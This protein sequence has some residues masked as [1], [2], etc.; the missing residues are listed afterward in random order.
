[1]PAAVRVVP[2]QSTHRPLIECRCYRNA[3]ICYSRDLIEHWEKH[4][5]LSMKFLT[6]FEQ[7]KIPEDDPEDNE[8]LNCHVWIAGKGKSDHWEYCGIAKKGRKHDSSKWVIRAWTTG[9]KLSALWTVQTLTVSTV[10][11]AGEPLL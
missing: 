2:C 6:A 7:V 1:M 5:E 10:S 8:D 3:G 9:G 11:A 4:H